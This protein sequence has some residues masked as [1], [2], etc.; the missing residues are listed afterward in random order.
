VGL[1]LGHA[2]EQ[3]DDDRRIEPER[4]FEDRA[5]PRAML[6][7]IASRSCFAAFLAYDESEPY[8]DGDCAG[9]AADAAGGGESMIARMP[10][11][12]ISRTV[13]PRRAASIFSRR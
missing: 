2:N 12:T 11:A 1:L 13:R 9:S 10:S 7:R 5:R 6:A 8:H 3:P 4:H